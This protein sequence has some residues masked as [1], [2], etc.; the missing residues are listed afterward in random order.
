MIN[1]STDKSALRTET[2]HVSCV[3]YGFPED[4]DRARQEPRLRSIYEGTPTEALTASP[5]YL[6]TPEEYA[7]QQEME[8]PWRVRGGNCIAD[9]L[10]NDCEGRDGVLYPVYIESDKC[11]EKGIQ[12]L[13]EWFR[14]FLRD[15]LDI[16][17][18]D[19][20]YYFSGN[21]SVHVHVPRVLSNE[22]DL[23]Q[24]RELAK[25]YCEETDGDLDCG[26][27]SRKRQFRLPGVIHQK[28]GLPKIRIE[29]DWDDAEIHEALTDSDHIKPDT[30]ADV[31]EQTF[32][33]W[34]HP[35]DP[36]RSRRCASRGSLLANIGG[37]EAVLSF[38]QEPKKA[39][40]TR[41]IEQKA[42][43]AAEEELRRWESYNRKEFSPYAHA[44]SGNGRSVAVFRVIAG[45]FARES[46]RSGATLVP[47]YFYGAHGCRGREFTMFDSYAPLQLSKPDYEKWAFEIGDTGV[48]IG[49]RNRN[50]RLIEVD[51]ATALLT[52]HLLHPEEGSRQE[53]LA[54]LEKEGYDTGSAGQ[55]C[56]GGSKKTKHRDEL[57]SVLPVDDP[58]VSESARLQ[59][60]A[61]QEG[62]QMLGHDEK[63]Q[64]AFRLLTKY[65]WEPVWR[66]FQS[67]FGDDF[68]PEVTWTQLKSVVEAFPDQRTHV[69]VPTR[70]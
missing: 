4:S 10:Q 66:W 69:K 58:S 38:D 19:C 27:Y 31:L 65:N 34:S 6:L 16:A 54:F 68:K 52:G 9:S 47:A 21:R 11:R 61:E 67:Q 60:R 32:G 55:P 23:V 20:C 12:P 43:P 49:G 33:A 56:S 44:G 50:S 14:C 62:I 45:P 70:P 57:I 5:V 35:D 26:I 48:I 3:R 1:T 51:T 59:Y 25:T 30:F 41:L 40:A 37:K 46:I 8:N 18:E 15:W 7:Q 64:V 36:E 29:S 63:R 17:P 42:L 22:K 13:L 24:L 39:I 2:N 28:T 53:A